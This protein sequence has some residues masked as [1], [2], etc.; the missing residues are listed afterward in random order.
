MK[1][2]YEIET[3]SAAVRVE[4]RSREQARKIAERMGHTVR[5]INMIG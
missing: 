5:S 4:A 3:E 2:L 1:H